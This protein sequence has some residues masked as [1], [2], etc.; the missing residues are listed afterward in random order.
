M[1]QSIQPIPQPSQGTVPPRKDV[2]V[3]IIGVAGAGKSYVNPLGGL[4]GDS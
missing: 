4:A 1:V 2:Y 3:A